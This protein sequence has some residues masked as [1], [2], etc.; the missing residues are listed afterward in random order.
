MPKSSSL[1]RSLLVVWITLASVAGGVAHADDRATAR[2]AYRDGTR[3]YEVGEFA[4]ALEA[5]KRAYLAYPDPSLLFNLGQCYR[6]L[7]VK[8]DAVRSYRQFLNKVPDA[9]NRADVERLIAN[10]EASICRRE[11]GQGGAAAGRDRREAQRC[12][13]RQR[14]ARGGARGDGDDDADAGA[15][16]DAAAQEVVAVDARRRRGRR[17]RRRRPRRRADP[18]RRHQHDP[19]RLRTGRRPRA[20][21]PV[22]AAR[23]RAAALAALGALTLGGCGSSSTSVLLTIRAD[24]SVTDDVLATMKTLDVRVTGAEMYAQQVS[25]PHPFSSSRQETVNYRALATAGSVVFSIYGRDANNQAIAYGQATATL[26]NK[27]SVPALVVLTNQIPPPVDVDQS[28]VVVD[29]T[30]AVANGTD[31]ITVTVTVLDLDGNPLPGQTVQL[32]ATGSANTW[33]QPA[34]PTDANGVATGTLVSSVA[35][36]KTI[37]AT[38]NPGL[39]QLML[40]QMPT[41]T[42][43]P[44]SAVALKFTSQPGNTV[45]NAPLAPAVQVSVVDGNGAVVSSANPITLTL[46][47]NPTMASLTGDVI[48]TSSAGVASFANLAVTQVGTG[49]TIVASSPGLTSA[50]SSAFNVT[51]GTTGWYE[52]NN[53]LY[54]GT[55]NAIFPDP[56]NSGVAYV[57]VNTSTLVR[58]TDGGMTWLEADSGIAAGV[59]WMSF[60]PSAPLTQLA[61]DYNGGLYKTTN[62]GA[63]WSTLTPTGLSAAGPIAAVLYDPNNGNTVYLQTAPTIVNMAIVPTAMFKSTDGGATFAAAGS[64]LDTTTY[65]I[66]TQCFTADPANGALYVGISDTNDTAVV[67]KSTDQAA[68]WTLTAGYPATGNTTCNGMAVEPGTSNVWAANNNGVYELAGG[69]G[70]WTSMSTGLSGAA[71]AIAIKPGTPATMYTLSGSFKLYSSPTTTVSWGLVTLPSNLNQQNSV[72]AIAADVGGQIVYVGHRPAGLYRSSDGGTTWVEG[73]TGIRGGAIGALAVDPAVPTSVYAATDAK[74][75]HSSDGGSSWTAVYSVPLGLLPKQMAI[76]YANSVSFSVYLGTAGGLYVGSNG[77]SWTLSANTPAGKQISSIAVNPNHV[78]DVFINPIGL[79]VY[80]S[81]NYSN[82]FAAVNNATLPSSGYTPY[83]FGVDSTVSPSIVYASVFSATNNLYS[84]TNFGAN[85]TTVSTTVPQTCNA[86]TIDKKVHTT[87]YCG[88]TSGVSKSTN[89][90]SSWLA[91]GLAADSVAVLAVDPV[92]DANV[93]AATNK[94]VFKSTDG[95]G[96]WNLANTGISELGIQQL[97]MDPSTPATLYAGTS[98]HGVFKTTTAAQ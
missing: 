58:T 75:F 21:D 59:Q 49:Y 85:W 93:Y 9:P 57:A 6:Q 91:A 13:G 80:Y 71:S 26:Q 50:T 65:Q 41:V 17:R 38:V 1:S 74:V 18:R 44:T 89:S 70:S 79:G 3:L 25:L 98:A 23:L 61:V 39:A 24:S 60:H 52:A 64:G 30:S 31:A 94:G 32:D 88:G 20:G 34:Q 54:G 62:G 36:D 78:Q 56:K 46:G 67:Y 16:G 69:A 92:T 95:A 45:V 73:N 37:T 27:K 7:G 72:F 8:P 76:N 11:G 96:T 2:E 10:L 5:F 4:K 14:A 12:T 29:K 42:F 83:S 28:T 43:T 68:T 33:T 51:P 63:S 90:G 47:A 22:S 40:S 48:T 15:R 86:L 84:T 87:I 19:A 35:E 53:G 82:S 66:S 77:T 97:A 81:G 55:I